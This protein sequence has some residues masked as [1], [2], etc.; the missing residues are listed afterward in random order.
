MP[1]KKPMRTTS[2]SATHSVD[3]HDMITTM[4]PA[5]TIAMPKSR[6]RARSW[7]TLG[8]SAMP[9]PSPMKTAPNSSP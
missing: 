1:A 9:S 3:V 5:P 6:S 2:S 7:A 8:P 4:I